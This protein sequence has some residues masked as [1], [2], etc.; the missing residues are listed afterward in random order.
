MKI[1]LTFT[2]FHDPY[3]LGLIGEEKQAGPI[4]SLASKKSFDQI[5]LL[6]TPNTDK[7]TIETKKAIESLYPSL[8]VKTIEFDI[9]DPTDY[10]FILKGL[11]QTF[12]E[13]CSDC[14]KANYFVSV[15]SGT[16]QM[17]ACWFLLV[18]SGEIPAHILNVRPP[19]FV[20]KD[21][22]LI[23]EVNP[24]SPEFP[25]IRS[26]IVI[27]NIPESEP[28]DV[29][30]VI[31]ELGI[32]GDHDSMK[33]ALEVGATLAP[34]DVP[35]LILGETGTGKELFAKLIHRLSGRPPAKFFPVNCA[36]IPKELVE[37]ILFGH[38]KG[39][40][41]GALKDQLGKFD[42]A[43]GGTLFLDELAELP[44]S[45]QAKLLR[46]LQDGIVEPVGD[47]KSH[48]VSVRIIAATN[49][50]IRKLVSKEKFRED[51]Y[52]RLNVGEIT[53]PPLRD[54]KTDIPKISLYILD[55]INSSLKKPRRL[56][57]EALVRLQNHAWPGNV[58]DLQNT[59]ER[60]ARLARK[61]VLDADDLLILEPVSTS[62]PL[63]FLPEPAEGFSLEAHIESVR[64]Q[65]ILRAMETSKGN[66]SAAARLLNIT[67]QAVN[68]FIKKGYYFKLKL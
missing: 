22:P 38:K 30:I 60:S 4:L 56:S 66:Q 5:Y 29:T 45:V 32:V 12:K 7:N 51:L 15:T 50:N 18:A 1:L 65:L 20:T 43:D 26:S 46:V 68:K 14:D 40:F 36:A 59:L 19:R 16:P 21:K 42:L 2:G 6:S 47:E 63:A 31:R 61:D 27:D 8:Q 34:S 37:S 23:E 57:P 62:D 28:P 44:L 53:L 11:R 52:Y 25:L 13:I 35:I 49:Q 24:S 54:R 64:K 39:S 10:F 17:H 48:G 41:T 58:R 9:I 3:S 67:P 55:S 33:K